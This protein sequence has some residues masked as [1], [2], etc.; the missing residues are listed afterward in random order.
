[1]SIFGK[2]EKKPLKTIEAEELESLKKFHRHVERESYSTCSNRDWKKLEALAEQIGELKEERHTQIASES[3]F[4]KESKAL[5]M[6][7][8][9]ELASKDL[10]E[11]IF[12]LS[13]RLAGNHSQ[14]NLN[15][16]FVDGIREPEIRGDPK[17]YKVAEKVKN[18]SRQ[19]ETG[20]NSLKNYSVNDSLKLYSAMKEINYEL[21]QMFIKM[22]RRNAEDRK[23]EF[24][25]T[26]D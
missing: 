10:A 18:S 1:M 17:H 8:S 6:L 5:N 13:N 11:D 20:A 7:S 19:I 25:A 3:G 16:K 26:A 9:L 2:S 22:S 4:G 12:T 21:Y 23:G 15:F 24:T 14:N